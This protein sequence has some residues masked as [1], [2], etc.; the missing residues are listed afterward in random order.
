MA[1]KR[2]A[3]IDYNVHL[4]ELALNNWRR[5]MLARD[6][7]RASSNAVS[8]TGSHDKFWRFLGG[9]HLGLAQL[10]SGRATSALDA[11]L[12]AASA[13]SEAQALSSL[14]RALAAHTY[15]EQD[16]PAEALRVLDHAAQTHELTYWRALAWARSSRADAS[17]RAAETIDDPLLAQHIA[18]E[19]DGDLEPLRRAAARCT[20]DELSSPAPYVPVL[21]ALGNALAKRVE[22]TEA[23][24]VFAEIRNAHS[25]VLHWPIP[26]VRS[27][28]RLGELS[29]ASD[30]LELAR[31][32]FSEL[33][34]FWGDGEMDRGAIELARQ[35]VNA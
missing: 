11:F 6:P 23:A 15:L 3:S 10:A 25:A 2:P 13:Y 34:Q 31:D 18:W 30:N 21:F 22:N 19:L 33:L 35:F 24:C 12:R 14:P 5:A 29:V 26:Y 1:T 7:Q 20:H 16:S 4:H 9:T 32:A 27:L 28:A 17:R 8:L